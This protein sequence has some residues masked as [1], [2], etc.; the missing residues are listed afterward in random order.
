M[1]VQGEYGI[2]KSSIANYTQLVAEETYGLHPIYVPLGGAK[3]LDDLALAIL[4]AT[5][6]SISKDNTKLKNIRNWLGKYIGNQTLFGFELKLSE[7]KA[8]SPRLKSA[9]ELLGFLH[10]T[11]Q[12]TKESGTKGI[13]LVLDEIN[14]IT[15]NPD[16]AHFLKGIVD[17]NALSR[18]Q[19]PILLML[20]GV[21][22]RLREMIKA[23]E[24]INRVF[25]VVTVDAMSA[26]EMRGFFLKAFASV[27]MQITSEGLDLLVQ[28]SAGLPKVMHLI[29]DHAYWRDTD[30]TVD[31]QDAARAVISAA[32]DVGSKYVDPQVYNTLKSPDYKSILK[33]IS[34]LGPSVTGFTRAQMHGHLAPTEKKKF[35]NFL[36]KM[37]KLNV[38]RPGDSP[39]SYEFN[40]RM[41]QVYIWLKNER[42]G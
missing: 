7:I 4:Q 32:E 27:P 24:P 22:A 3:S 21:E 23:H 19:V 36:Q 37:K 1:F 16:F 9:L 10:E 28:Y 30:G 38:V 42:P 15:A 34:A 26:E 33:K 11:I 17:Q 40:I 31:E 18:N 29:G 35:D 6:R 5:V 20:C 12:Q 13:F 8:D 39:G 14:G 2:G 25:D 41:V